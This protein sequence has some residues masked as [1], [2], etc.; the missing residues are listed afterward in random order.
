MNDDKFE[1]TPIVDELAN[2]LDS[3]EQRYKHHLE[4]VTVANGYKLDATPEEAFNVVSTPVTVYFE[5]FINSGAV[6]EELVP[7]L[8]SL[9]NDFVASSKSSPVE[10]FA[11][12]KALREALRP[13]EN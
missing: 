7:A 2:A 11:K 1:Q 5:M 6:D 3:F 8:Q 10:I 9:L 12:A 13:Y 4:T